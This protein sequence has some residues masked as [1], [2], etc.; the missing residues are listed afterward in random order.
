MNSIQADNI[1]DIM[2]LPDFCL[3]YVSKTIKVRNLKQTF[4]VSRIYH[5]Y[6]LYSF[7]KNQL[8]AQVLLQWR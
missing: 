3:M 1:F 7:Q 4:K 8:R 5:V 2:Q 6:N